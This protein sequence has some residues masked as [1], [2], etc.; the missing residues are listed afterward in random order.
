LHGVFHEDPLR[1]TVV[2]DS[3]LILQTHDGGILWKPMESGVHETLY[4]VS[5]ARSG[6]GLAVGTGGVV[7]RKALAS[8]NPRTVTYQAFA[9]WNLVSVPVERTIWEADSVFAHKSGSAFK[10]DESIGDYRVVSALAKGEGYWVYY[11]SSRAEPI[12]GSP[13]FNWSRSARRGGWVLIGSL[14]DPV[15]ANTITTL[16]SG[17]LQAGPFRYNQILGD[18]EIPTEL[19]PSD[20]HW[21]LVADSC[22]VGLAKGSPMTTPFAGAASSVATVIFRDSTGSAARLIIVESRGSMSLVPL[23]P[24]PHGVKGRV[25]V[26]A[27]GAEAGTYGPV[28]DFEIRGATG[29]L[30]VTIE[31]STDI[32]LAL[33]SLGEVQFAATIR[34]HSTIQ[35]PRG[36]KRI[37][38]S[39]GEVRN[40]EEPTVNALMQN[41]PNPFNPRTRIAFTLAKHCMVSLTLVNTL[42]QQVATLARGSK[43]AGSHE[44]VLDASHLPSGVYIYRLQA[45][46]YSE[47]RKLLLL[48]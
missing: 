11:D 25:S 15:P 26:V 37:R 27:V 44:V 28:T 41:Y 22:T 19:M 29:S 6:V 16:P 32:T 24:P 3:G 35:V 4:G 17:L 36:V 38:V 46:D 34:G 8:E 39:F 30:S 43:E 33:E 48:K 42:G 12:T 14:S 2:G 1:I 21:V 10:Y 31:G 23:P 7:L 5:I 9:G 13:V 47:T 18:Y 40:D 20:G 45:G